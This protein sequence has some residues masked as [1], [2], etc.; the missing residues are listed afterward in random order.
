LWRFAYWVN[1]E[2]ESVCVDSTRRATRGV[3]DQTSTR[4]P[5]GPAS[6][7]PITAA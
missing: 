1:R 4:N 2:R 6:V 3:V 7:R 5:A